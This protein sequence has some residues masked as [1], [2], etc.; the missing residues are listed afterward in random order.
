MKNHP[1]TDVL[2]ASIRH[3]CLFL[4]PVSMGAC[5]TIGLYT[6]L[7]ARALLSLKACFHARD[8]V[9]VVVVERVVKRAARS[10]A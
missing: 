3:A 7:Y 4:V 9:T 2:G 8:S 10:P 6:G 1:N 5:L